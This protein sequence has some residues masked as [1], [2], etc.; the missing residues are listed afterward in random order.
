MIVLHIT[1][2]KKR[3][4]YED[5][6]ER[7]YPEF[8]RIEFDDGGVEGFSYL[9]SKLPEDIVN[10]FYKSLETLKFIVNRNDKDFTVNLPI[11]HY[12]IRTASPLV[13]RMFIDLYEEGYFDEVGAKLKIQDSYVNSNTTSIDK[14]DWRLKKF[15][16]CD[17]RK[18]LR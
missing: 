10:D 18:I 16:E 12:L 11:S 14:N 13:V 7:D 9:Y 2:F 1:D 17:W 15:F 8:S 6:S 5:I 4:K 3:K